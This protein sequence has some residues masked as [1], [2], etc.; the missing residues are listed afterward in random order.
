[1]PEFAQVGTTQS[2]VAT[3]QNVSETGS[4]PDLGQVTPEAVHKDTGVPQSMA[5]RALSVVVLIDLTVMV[6][7]APPANPVMVYDAPALS[8]A[9]S[10]D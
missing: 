5:T 1:M 7:S 6:K 2:P 8:L 3:S 9:M 10:Q 4:T